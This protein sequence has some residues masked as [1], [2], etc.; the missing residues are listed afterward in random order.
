MLIQI[1]MLF[2]ER[3]LIKK[4]KERICPLKDIPINLPDQTHGAGFSSFENRCGKGHGPKQSMPGEGMDYL[5][6]FMRLSAHL[7]LSAIVSII[8]QV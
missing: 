8:N 7:S 4:S 1:D 6:R 3:I 5:L 2:K